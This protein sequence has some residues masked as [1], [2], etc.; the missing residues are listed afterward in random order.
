MQFD[1]DGDGQ[2]SRDEA[3]ERMS[4]FFDRL[5]GNGDG[6]IDQNEVDQMRSQFGGGGGPG[7][8]GQ[9]G[10]GPGG[11]G[12]PGGRR[13]ARWRSRRWQAGWFG[14]RFLMRPPRFFRIAN[15]AA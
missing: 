13:W 8:G 5:D 11:D 7:G 2:V 9:R 14:Q 6:F 12:G 1:K 3:P 10:G 15:H 4:S